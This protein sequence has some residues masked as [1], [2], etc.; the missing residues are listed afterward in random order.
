MDT[1]KRKNNSAWCTIHARHDLEQPVIWPE[2]C[3]AQEPALT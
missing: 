2:Y 1:A 3:P